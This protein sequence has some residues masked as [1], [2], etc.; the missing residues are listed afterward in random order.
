MGSLGFSMGMGM[1]AK[2]PKC[3][4]TLEDADFGIKICAN[5]DC[6]AMLFVDFDGSVQLSTDVAPEAPEAPAPAAPQPAAPPPAAPPPGTPTAES[7]PMMH[8]RSHYDS[9]SSAKEET[10]PHAVPYPGD[11]VPAEIAQEVADYDFAADLEPVETETP[12]ENLEVAA[13]YSEIDPEASAPPSAPTWLDQPSSHA[14]TVVLGAEE[15]DL[16]AH[17]PPPPPELVAASEAEGADNP[18]NEADWFDQPLDHQSFTTPEKMNVSADQTVDFSDVVEFANSAQLDHSPLA[19]TLW[20]EGIDSGEIRA[21]V[22]DVLSDSRL[23]FHLSDV[24]KNLKKGVLELRDLNP[25]KAS[26]IASRLRAEAVNF[27]WRQSIFG[28]DAESEGGAA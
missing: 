8:V 1:S 5:A 25:V 4:T 12:A 18:M 22:E 17:I 27:R 11:E 15:P 9:A 28:A 3:K 6:G 23:N 13:E 26:Y 19:Y 20:I 21:R 16:A 2:C 14:E 24:M 7:V 10:F